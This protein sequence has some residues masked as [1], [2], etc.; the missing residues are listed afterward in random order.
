MLR[1]IF[2]LFCALANSYAITLN[3][4]KEVWKTN[5]TLVDGK[6]VPYSV[7]IIDG[8]GN[9]VL[10]EDVPSHNFKKNR[11][12]YAPNDVS[13]KNIDAKKI[14]DYKIIVTPQMITS[15]EDEKKSKEVATII[16]AWSKGI[17]KTTAVSSDAINNNVVAIT[18]NYMDIPKSFEIKL[19]E[20]PLP[21]Q[22]EFLE[23]MGQ[24]NVIIRFQK[25]GAT[26]RIC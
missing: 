11:G 15:T 2:I 20:S 14:L 25:T 3:I 16:K 7:N 13:L 6:T 1:T 21:K 10:S 12:R 4:S 9:C 8:D 17:N 5:L 23:I 19:S 18:E 22:E 26:Y 24:I